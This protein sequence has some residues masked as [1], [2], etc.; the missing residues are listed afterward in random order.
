LAHATHAIAASQGYVST[1]WVD[2]LHGLYAARAGRARLVLFDA[3]MT[4]GLGIRAAIASGARSSNQRH[5]R[6]MVAS[7]QRAAALLRRTLLHGR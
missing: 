2:A 5:R 4:V 1:R 6:R 3:I 7:A